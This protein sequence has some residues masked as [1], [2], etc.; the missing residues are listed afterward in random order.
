MMPC[1]WTSVRLTL[2]NNA[3]AFKP[4]DFREDFSLYSGFC[5]SSGN[6]D[7][8]FFSILAEH[9]T[10]GKNLE[11]FQFRELGL[12][13]FSGQKSKTWE[14]TCRISASLIFSAQI[15]K[16]VF[17]GLAYERQNTPSSMD[18]EITG[19]S[20]PANGGSEVQY[21]ELEQSSRE[22]RSISAEG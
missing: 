11:K 21:V 3:N 9:L 1:H 18:T 8:T 20:Q 13:F 10:S 22:N 2:A 5:L 6:L 12:K 4:T 7:L 14:I 16:S 19:I 15:R 17:A